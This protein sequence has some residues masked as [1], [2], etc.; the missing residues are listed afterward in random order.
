MQSFAVKH[1][2]GDAESS[3]SFASTRSECFLRKNPSFL[4]LALSLMRCW[5]SRSYFVGFAGWGQFCHCWG[6]VEIPPHISSKSHPALTLCGPAGVLEDG[7]FWKCIFLGISASQESLSVHRVI[8]SALPWPGRGWRIECGAYATLEL[9][10]L[11]QQI[12]AQRLV[13]SR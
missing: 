4:L 8:P 12:H 2:E 7:E 11:L 13:G 1:E 3:A 6:L 9:L 10:W 5:H